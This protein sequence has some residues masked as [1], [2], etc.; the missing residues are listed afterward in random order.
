MNE[1]EG[2]GTCNAGIDE[3]SEGEIGD[4][5]ERVAKAVVERL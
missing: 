4:H 3:M 2:C 5:A 1:Q